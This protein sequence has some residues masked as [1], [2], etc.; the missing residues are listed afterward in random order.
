VLRT[1]EKAS[2][3]SRDV[4]LLRYFR[5]QLE[6]L[7]DDKVLDIIKTLGT[8]SFT[9]RQARPLL[10]TTRQG[11]WKRLDSLVE[12]GFLEK[13]GYIYRVSPSA[14]SLIGAVCS[15]LRDLLTFKVLTENRS[16]AQEALQL[17]K[18]GV[19]LMY[20]KGMIQPADVSRHQKVLAE[21]ER[22]LKGHDE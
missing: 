20:A 21:L 11:A 8:A 13:R 3:L 22:V 10:G 15:A 7:S 14:A 12:L 2:G 4:E 17:A 9:N 16:P 18:Q 19:E 5:R 1:N 6:V